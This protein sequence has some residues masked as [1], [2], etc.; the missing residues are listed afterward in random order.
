MRLY[1]QTDAPTI[2]D[3]YN[4]ELMS[5]IIKFQQSKGLT[6]DGVVG[7]HTFILLNSELEAGMP[8]LNTR[9]G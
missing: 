1:G 5:Q 3:T 2:R 7:P 8:L 9:K 4:E 6:P